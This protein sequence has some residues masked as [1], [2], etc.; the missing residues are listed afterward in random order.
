MSESEQYVTLI[1]SLPPHLP[2]LFAN[3]DPPIS[4]LRLNDRLT[5]LEETDARQ[6]ANIEELLHWD[7]M[8]MTMSDDEVLRRVK[9]T[10]DEIESPLL[11]EFVSWRLETRTIQVALRRRHL[12]LPAPK[13]GTAWGFGP[14]TRRIEQRWH[15]P[16]FGIEQVHPWLPEAN[17]Q[18][19][20]GD[21]LGLE[22]SL[23]NQVW[24]YYGRAA[25]E[26][27]FDFEAVAVYVMRW[28]VI[29]R[30]SGYNARAAEQRFNAMVDA[31]MGD[32][33]AIFA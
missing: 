12:G 9:S 10:I 4:R 2:Q 15:E 17:K 11:L 16:H 18:L 27:Y 20:A 29:A 32:H 7:R 23:L 24:N 30:W 5:M 14:W 22:R 21:Y 31:A 8:S 1:A 28:D 19:K 25:D 3:R 13:A 6:L 33:A 26:H